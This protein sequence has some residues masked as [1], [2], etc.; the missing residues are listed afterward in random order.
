VVPEVGSQ[1]GC[2]VGAEQL[3]ACQLVEGQPGVYQERPGS[4][5]PRVAVVL[6]TGERQ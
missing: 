1:E 6:I 5:A 4:T 2:L 3:L